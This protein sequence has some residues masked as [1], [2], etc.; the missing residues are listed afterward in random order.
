[1]STY[2]QAHNVVGFLDAQRDAYFYL[3]HIVGK[4]IA[5]VIAW[6]ITRVL[7]VVLWFVIRRLRSDQKYIGQMKVS[8][9]NYKNL[10]QDFDNL[11]NDLY[12]LQKF[13]RLNFAQLPFGFKGFLGDIKE[14]AELF[15][16]RHQQI[17]QLLKQL[18][19]TNVNG[20]LFKHISEAELWNRRTKAY[21]YLV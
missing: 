11:S 3:R 20:E 14:I 13:T 2:Q 4:A 15:I 9:N 18:D 19:A 1:M 17:G 7:R 21:D 12:K 10:R 8:I 6:A 16:T 5:I